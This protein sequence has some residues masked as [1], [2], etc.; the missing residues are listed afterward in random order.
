M[1]NE[2]PKFTPGPYGVYENPGTAF[3]VITRPD[4]DGVRIV[5]L[6][7]KDP[8]AERQIEL[9]H[10]AKLF[11]AAPDLLMALENVLSAVAYNDEP[12]RDILNLDEI[13][14]AI[15]KAKGE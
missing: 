1:K 7:V 6:A 4:K 15:A 13:R 10:T 9:E 12:A 11:K 5:G 2:K 14:A 8:E 3:M